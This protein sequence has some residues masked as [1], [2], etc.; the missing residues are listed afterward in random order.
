MHQKKKGFA[1][2]Y[3]V[4]NI[5]LCLPIQINYTSNLQKIS[6]KP[7][8]KFLV[9]LTDLFEQNWMIKQEVTSRGM[10]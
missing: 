5:N 9:I 10:D 2:S 4:D 8:T 3:I 6:L 7:L 1:H